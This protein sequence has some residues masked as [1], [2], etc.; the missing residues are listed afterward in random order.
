MQ[1]STHLNIQG[2]PYAYLQSFLSVQRPL[3]W[4]PENSSYL[5]LLKPPPLPTHIVQLVP[6]GFTLPA[7]SPRDS[8][9]AASWGIC[10]A[11]P[12]FFVCLFIFL[13]LHLWHIEVPRLG[14][15]SELQLLD[16]T[17]A[18]ARQDP[19][20]VWDLHHSSP[21]HQIPN[22][23]SEAGDWTR[24][25]KDTSQVRS[26]WTTKAIPHIFFL[27]SLRDTYLSLLD[28]H[29]LEIHCFIYF[30]SFLTCF[31]QDGKSCP[32]Y[33]ILV[34]SRTSVCQYPSYQFLST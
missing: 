22:P 19:S 27:S 21:Q 5:G 24:V 25:L 15:E 12:I 23:I 18:T 1:L 14:V 16:Y 8:L 2:G 11:Y 20:R 34:P 30:L 10:K 9:K 3:L 31:R 32:C 13:G 29:C 26:W 33:S 6:H 17:T 28:D 7:L 4:Q